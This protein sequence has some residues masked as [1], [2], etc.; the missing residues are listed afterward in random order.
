[1]RITQIVQETTTS[2]SVAT[3]A[4]PLLKGAVTRNPSIYGKQGKPGSMFKGKVTNKPFVNSISESAIKEEEISE[5]D[6]ILVPGQGRKFKTGFVPHAQDRTD[7]EVE[8]ALSDLFQAAKNAKEVYQIVKT[9]SEEEGLEGWVQEKIIKANDYLNTIR[10][11]LEHRQL[12]KEGMKGAMVGGAAG[13][14]ITKTPMGSLKGASLGSDIEDMFKEAIHG[15]GVIGNGMAG[16]SANHQVE[17]G[18]MTKAM[19]TLSEILNAAD[20]QKDIRVKIGNKI[21]PISKEYANTIKLLFSRANAVGKGDRFVK[22]FTS[23][24]SFVELITNPQFKKAHIQA[25]IKKASPAG[26]RGTAI[27]KHM[28]KATSGVEEKPKFDIVAEKA[29]SKA[30]QKF[31]GIVHEAQKGE[32][33]QALMK[34]KKEIEAQLKQDVAEGEGNK[35]KYEMMM[36]NGQVKKFIAKDDADAKR[37]AAG[38][39]AKSVIKMKGNVPGGKIAEQGVAEGERTMSRAAKGYE[40]YGKQGMQALAKA[41]REGKDLDKIRDKYNKYDEGAKVD[42]MVKHIEKS[43]EKAGKSKKEAENIAWATANKRGMLNNKNKK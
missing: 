15:A 8:M 2:G 31:M 32:K 14:A 7:H 40:K 41:G 20:E 4:Q 11:Y 10:E 22:L 16:E 38:H 42:R 5:Q 33:R 3:V 34:Q 21:G 24:P 28:D 26:F 9:Y 36:R 37:I 30:Q 1:M 35:Q 13:A 25:N 29:V 12:T 18:P 43:E 39:G 19:D 27:Y 23:V 6:L 17:G